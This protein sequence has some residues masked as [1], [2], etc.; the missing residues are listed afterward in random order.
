M[1]SIKNSSRTLLD[2]VLL[3][4]ATALI[5]GLL[6]GSRPYSAPSE[7]R[8]IEIGREMAE[9]GDY[10][11]PR[12]NYVKYFEKPPLFYWVQALWTE[13]AGTDFFNARVP[14]VFF[15]V[16][17][18]LLTYALGR[19]L[20]GRLA[21]ILS[22][23]V[24]ATS[25]YLFS[26][27]RVV[28]L[29]VPVS[30]FLVATLTAFLYA[31]NAPPGKRRTLVIYSMY[32]AAAGAV[33]TKGLIGIVVPGAI[34]FLWFVSTWRWKLL[35]E[36]RLPTGTLLFL[37]LCAPWHIMVWQ[38]NPEHPWF[39]F[40]HEHWLRYT[41]TTHGRDHKLWFFVPVVLGGL[42]PWIVFAWQAFSTHLKGGWRNRHEDSRPLFLALWIWFPFI[43]FSISDSTLIPYLLPIFPP[44]AV[45]LGHYFAQ[46][47]QE[48]KTKGWRAGVWAMIVLLLMVTFLPDT[49]E[50]SV[51]QNSKIY[52]AIEDGESS[53]Q[54]LSGVALT[55]AILLFIT[56]M[57]GRAK[58]VIMVMIAVTTLVMQ[59]GDV[60]ASNYNKDSMQSFAGT[61]KPILKAE[62]EVVI[63]D[64][65]YQDMPIYLNRR[66]GTVNW[67]GELE[68]GSQHQDTSGWLLSYD[69]F[70]KRWQ[71]TGKRMFVIM[72]QDA[73][74]RIKGEPGYKDIPL[75]PLMQ[76][77][78]NLLFAN[79]PKEALIEKEKK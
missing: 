25:I 9:S 41:T 17:L 61:L 47:W 37:A 78:R 70:W 52:Q 72:R 62:D 13:V 79:V 38:A 63:Y 30:V 71:T 74:E 39:Y 66:I 22:A 75:Y 8:Y 35:A 5:F 10:V 57:Q 73:L 34:I 68:F 15:S 65:Y 67:L 53:I 56:Y 59:L 51:D 29:D 49:V 1:Q 7:S 43:F 21:G 46:N 54:Y 42:F 20:Y 48:Q 2:L 16:L 64:H 36:M 26:L 55:G 45:M 14:T 69:E 24:I 33:M 6:L 31:A 58:H 44:L 12:L 18:C 28:L 11:T 32:V 50:D 77:G 19:M 3:A 60:I 40:I 23:L 4:L 27:S 76:D